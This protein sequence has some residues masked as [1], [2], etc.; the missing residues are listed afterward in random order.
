V[1]GA[2]KFKI[3][4]AIWALSITS[5]AFTQISARAEKTI[6]GVETRL[7]ANRTYVPGD[8]VELEVIATAR[9]YVDLLLEPPVHPQARLLEIQPFPITLNADSLFQRE[10]MVLYQI[11]R[12]GSLILDGGSV[13]L[14]SEAISEIQ[15]LAAISL[16]VGSVG[17]DPGGDTPEAWSGTDIAG[18]V[19]KFLIIAGFFALGVSMYLAYNYWR[20]R[21]ST[22]A[23]GLPVDSAQV[24]ASRI[25]EDLKREDFNPRDLERFLAAHQGECS[26]RLVALIEKRLYARKFPIDELLDQFRKEFAE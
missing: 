9:S 1:F 2:S 25:C 6:V 8:V 23:S 16:D 15:E 12:S 20:K 22:E 26:R 21:N 14:N 19:G 7:D 24:Q 5:Q 11:G 10:W 17:I 13:A 18:G 3:S 4:L